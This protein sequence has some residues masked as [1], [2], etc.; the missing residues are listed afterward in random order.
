MDIKR[1]STIIVMFLAV[2]GAGWKS[3]G[4]FAKTSEVVALNRKVDCSNI[5]WAYESMRDRLWKMESTGRTNTDE[6]RR[7]KD[8]FRIKEEQLKKCERGE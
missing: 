6:Y 4:H 7:L 5:R 2:F 8:D 1:I 3:Y